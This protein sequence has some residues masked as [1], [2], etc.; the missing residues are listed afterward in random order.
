MQPYYADVSVPLRG[1]GYIEPLISYPSALSMATFPS[2]CGERVISNGRSNLL[3]RLPTGSVSV[4]LRGKGYIE[5]QVALRS[6]AGAL[7]GFPSP[8]GERVISNAVVSCTGRCVCP[9]AFPSPCGERVISNRGERAQ[10]HEQRGAHVSVPLR[11]KGYIEP[12][13]WVSVFKPSWVWVSVP[14]RG[15]GYI[16]HSR[17]GSRA[18]ADPGFP[19]PC[20]ERVI[21][22]N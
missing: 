10:R 18:R 5:H 1:K 19:S 9:V 3:M 16:E 7:S 8:C 12:L 22:N 14:L 13:S 17:R 11:G 15:K 4:P 6:V 21:S 2:P 20:G